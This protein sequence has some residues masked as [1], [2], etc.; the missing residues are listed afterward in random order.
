MNYTPTLLSTSFFSS[1]WQLYRDNRFYFIQCKCVTCSS[2]MKFTLISPGPFAELYPY[3]IKYI[4]QHIFP[5]FS[6]TL[7]RQ[8]ILFYS[9]QM[10]VL[11][12]SEMTFKLIS[13]EP[14]A[15]LYPYIIK[16]VM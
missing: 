9:M 7:P 14:F 10:S 2:E 11:N 5:E 6:V 4:M 12:S 1:S 8:Q 13:P 3:I 15:E 16:Y